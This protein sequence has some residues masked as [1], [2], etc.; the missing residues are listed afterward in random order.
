MADSM[1]E[2]AVLSN[3][4]GILANRILALGSTEA[5]IA[6]H[7]TYEVVSNGDFLRRVLNEFSLGSFLHPH[8]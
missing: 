8:K 7:A 3:R 2:A 5:L 6:E 1:E 4:V